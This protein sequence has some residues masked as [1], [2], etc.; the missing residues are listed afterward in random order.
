MSYTGLEKNTLMMAISP[1][2]K[3][4]Q[5]W[6]C[7]HDTR[8]L[9]YNKDTHLVVINGQPFDSWMFRKKVDRMVL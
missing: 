4:Y 3:L 9:V 1:T 8:V 2:G 7:L 5:Y 6:S